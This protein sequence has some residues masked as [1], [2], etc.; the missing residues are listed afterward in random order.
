[1]GL[2]DF[3]GSL[4]QT[5]ANRRSQNR[6]NEF[7]AQQAE[8]NRQF[9]SQEAQIARDW[10]EQQYN[11][12]SSPSAMVRQYQDAGLN[13]ALMYG[14]N[15]QS[16]TGSSPAP[17]G[18]MASGSPL[19]AGMPTGN[20]ID[21]VAGLAKLKAEI[22]NI[23]ADTDA[24]RA[25]TAVAYSGIELN[26]ASIENMSHQNKKILNDI[27]NNN[28]SVASQV[29]LIEG[30]LSKIA[31][32][33]KVSQKQIEHMDSAIK[34]MANQNALSDQQKLTLAAQQTLL[35]FQAEESYLR[36][37]EILSK[38]RLNNAQAGLIPMQE[39]EQKFKNK[40]LF[41]YGTY[42]PAESARESATK[43][44]SKLQKPFKIL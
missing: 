4:F 42:P 1:M 35:E 7:N 12:Y 19:G 25:S 41:L 33:N 40:Y 43:W 2:L 31:Q 13:P 23:D 5:F 6:Q 37:N 11:M 30:Q 32:D 24:K 36:Q 34:Q 16:S 44:T 8:F 39:W 26:R 22:N 20:I 38:V 29:K 18:S 10:Q 15:L 27:E 14:Q 17:S 9:Q 28:K 3:A 21:A